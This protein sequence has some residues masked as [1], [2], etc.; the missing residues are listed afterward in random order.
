MMKN[1]D[2]RGGSQSWV[3][4]SLIHGLTPALVLNPIPYELFN[5]IIFG[6]L[7]PHSPLTQR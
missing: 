1:T 3:R 4:K 6:L 5:S 7:G 2:S